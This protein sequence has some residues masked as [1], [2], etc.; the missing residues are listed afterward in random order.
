[1]STAYK[2]SLE[3]ATYEEVIKAR[4]AKKEKLVGTIQ[5]AMGWPQRRGSKDTQESS[6]C[7]H[8][9]DRIEV[10]IWKEAVFRRYS[11]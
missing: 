10:G 4:T 9:V 8:W 2:G 7:K 11:I 1:M 6:S 3:N 5:S